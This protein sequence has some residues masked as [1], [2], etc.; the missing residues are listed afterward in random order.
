M[1]SFYALSTILYL[2]GLIKV[3]SALYLCKHPKPFIKE[4]IVDSY[5]VSVICYQQYNGIIYVIM[6]EMA[7]TF[8]LCKH[9][10]LFIG[11]NII[12]YSDNSDFWL[13]SHFVKR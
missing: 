1:N 7:L 9:P 10:K 2:L 12:L 8:Y 6:T 5:T 4:G 11:H 13:L 3:A